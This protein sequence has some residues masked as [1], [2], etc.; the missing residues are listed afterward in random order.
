M[1]FVAAFLLS[2]LMAQHA[3][4]W[5]A[6]A[7]VGGLLFGGHDYGTESLSLYIS[8]FHP[9][10]LAMALASFI[11]LLA[12]RQIEPRIDAFCRWRADAL[13]FAAVSAGLVTIVANLILAR[14]LLR[15]GRPAIVVGLL[16]AFAFKVL[17]ILV[18][19]RAF[20][21]GSTLG[22]ATGARR[23][24]WKLLI[25]LA[26]GIHLIFPPCRYLISVAALV[27][28]GGMPSWLSPHSPGLPALVLDAAAALLL[29]RF[30]V[31][32]GAKD[33][34]FV[35]PDAPRAVRIAIRFL[36]A[37]LVLAP[38]VAVLSAIPYGG[39]GVPA[40]VRALFAVTQ[41]IGMYLLYQGLVRRTA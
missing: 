41:A 20:K 30:L 34:V 35:P 24:S 9:V 38:V 19:W 40:G 23:I 1:P 31:I 32:R 13:G 16:L 7:G 37:F 25:V 39:G 11:A 28:P 21:A 6:Q 27:L 15:I 33:G 8:W 14:E 18:I 10:F 5:M 22:S 3:C 2:V 29:A 12:A 26:A 17:A 36:L 4:N